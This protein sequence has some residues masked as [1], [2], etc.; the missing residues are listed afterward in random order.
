ME[1]LPQELWDLV[2]ELVTAARVCRDFHHA[3]FANPQTRARLTPRFDEVESQDVVFDDGGR[4][5]RFG[6]LPTDITPQYP[7][8]NCNS[9]YVHSGHTLAALYSPASA[10]AV[11]HF[12]IDCFPNPNFCVTVTQAVRPKGKREK[13]F[14]MHPTLLEKTIAVA[15]FPDGDI[16]R[17][18]LGHRSTTQFGQGDIISVQVGLRDMN[19]ASSNEPS[20]SQVVRMGAP[21]SLED[22]VVSHNVHPYV[23][24]FKNFRMVHHPLVFPYMDVSESPLRVGVCFTDAGE[25]VRIVAPLSAGEGQFKPLLPTVPG[26]SP[27]V[28]LARKPS[29]PVAD[30]QTK[31][32]TGTMKMQPGSCQLC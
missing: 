18:G 5:A 19:A 20:W 9:A 27:A 16:L 23:I 28:V 8:P 31:R 2:R 30:N 4:C 14:L 12:R 22:A 32:S 25:N 1:A 11:V 26:T 15:Y 7:D 24:F 3:I 6:D 13:A 10:P 17:A 21:T 29:V